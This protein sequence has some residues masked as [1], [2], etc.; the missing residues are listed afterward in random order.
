MATYRPKGQKTY[1]LDFQFQKRRI[2]ESTGVTT[3]TLA[4]RI[5][6]ERR[7]GL[8]EGIAGFTKPKAMPFFGTV[9]DEFMAR[10]KKGLPEDE[11]G[12]K[13]STVRIDEFNVKHLKPYF[14]NK[15]LCDISADDIAEYQDQRRRAGA[16]PKTV[17]LELGTFR[18]IIKPSGHWHR[19]LPETD[20][21]Q[22]RND[23]GICLEADQQAAIEEA[24]SASSSRLLY[25]VIILLV[26]TGARIATIRRLQWKQVNL[27]K[28]IL[29]IGIDKTQSGD[30]RWVP[31]S[32]RALLVLETWAENFPNR[33]PN[34][35]VFPAE[36]Y[37]QVKGGGMMIVSSDPTT[38]VTSLQRS[39]ETAQERA[40][41][42]LAGRP[43]DGA[44]ALHCRFHDLR[45]TAITR[46]IEG[47][48]PLPVIAQLVGWSPAQMVLMAARYSHHS[49]DVLR[50]AVETISGGESPVG[51]PPKTESR[52]KSRGLALSRSVSF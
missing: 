24:C 33:K 2:Y 8:E 19:L 27:A 21:L 35:H 41:W 5:E 14:G 51:E 23:I 29:K 12:G 17:N 18:S 16:A 45:H 3:K 31:I 42:I 32:Q 20:M 4:D 43:E 40:G 9:A 39:W 30:F 1:V 25:P 50:K 48:T 15:L 11:E 22:V 49:L 10:R 26:E 37:R 52:G 47:N 6:R 34:D 46:M 36:T 13:A 38:H 28:R 7:R 44:E